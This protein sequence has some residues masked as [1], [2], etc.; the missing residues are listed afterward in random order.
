MS[1]IALTEQQQASMI[2]TSAVHNPTPSYGSL[3]ES[4]LAG[5]FLDGPCSYRDARSGQ[6][7]PRVD[8]FQNQQSS[9]SPMDET[10]SSL[11]ERIQQAQQ[12]QAQS[13][14]A[15]PTTS[16][17]SNMMNS[18][19]VQQGLAQSFADQDQALCLENDKYLST[20]L[21][22]LELLQRGLA[23]ADLKLSPSTS[24]IPEATNVSSQNSSY[25]TPNNYDG[26]T[27]GAALTTFQDGVGHH[28]HEEAQEYDDDDHVEGHHHDDEDIFDLD[29]E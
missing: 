9:S 23:V 16:T 4:Q 29:M 3:R 20:S 22:G 7:K 21:T 26:T 18:T 10:T 25:T 19:T 15:T 11:G 17:L 1:P 12:Q 24:T 27:S 28:H 13:Q 5:R 2:A 6:I 14:E 8:R